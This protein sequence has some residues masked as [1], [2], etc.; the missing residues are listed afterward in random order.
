MI[1]FIRG[2]RKKWPNGVFYYKI[3]LDTDLNCFVV[4][5]FEAEE[6]TEVERTTFA[7]YRDAE[8]WVN[9]WLFY[10]QRI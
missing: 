5:M 3:D 2:F 8:E 1:T 7:T 6:Y 10:K 4:I 9:K